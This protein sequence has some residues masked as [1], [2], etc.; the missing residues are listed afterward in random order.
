MERFEGDE[1]LGKIFEEV[2]NEGY[3]GGFIFVDF[4]MKLDV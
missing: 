4:K 2:V 3:V 1:K